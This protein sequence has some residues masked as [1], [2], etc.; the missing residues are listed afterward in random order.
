MR[1]LLHLLAIK[2]DPVALDQAALSGGEAIAA[3]DARGGHDGVRV[4]WDAG[5]TNVYRYGARAA[6]TNRPCFDVVLAPASNL[7]VEAVT[8]TRASAGEIRALR[9]AAAQ[10]EA[11][12]LG[13]RAQRWRQR[14]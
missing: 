10:R 12:R 9:A 8:K 2:V 11:M 6:L 4:R 5:K 14:W 3:L 13:L 1:Q 7:A